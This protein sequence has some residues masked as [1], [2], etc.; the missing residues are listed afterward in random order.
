MGSGHEI[1]MTLVAA[2]IVATFVGLGA[3]WLGPIAAKRL[4]RWRRKRMERRALQGR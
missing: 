4:R 1:P 2:V 3:L